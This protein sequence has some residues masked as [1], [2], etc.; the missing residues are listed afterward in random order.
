MSDKSTHEN[1]AGSP[2]GGSDKNS[3]WGVI[4]EEVGCGVKT[5]VL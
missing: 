5:S 1:Y 3:H 4:R 2:G